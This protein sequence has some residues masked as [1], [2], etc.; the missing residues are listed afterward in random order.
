MIQFVRNL[1]LLGL[2]AAGALLT[3]PSP[4]HAALTLNISGGGV[5]S[6]T[7]IDNDVSSGDLNPVVG[8]I[9]FIGSQGTFSGIIETGTSNAL[10]ATEPA[11]LTIASTNL[12]TTAA[13]SLVLTLSDSPFTAPAPGPVSVNTQVSLTSNAPS[14]SSVT[15]ET[16]INGGSVNLAAYTIGLPAGGESVTTPYLL[17][18]SSYTLT[19]VFTVTLTGPGSAIVATGLSEVA[20]APVPEPATLAMFAT[21]LPLLGLGYWRRRRAQA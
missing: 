14:G 20:A 10:D 2:V 15:N 8:Q 11:Q 9:T 7:V 17:G 5:A 21:A 16:F 3:N 13:G 12:V 19:S 4:A 6:R 18:S 1:A